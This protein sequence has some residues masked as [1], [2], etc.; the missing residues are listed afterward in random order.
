MIFSPPR[1]KNLKV[2]HQVLQANKV[3]D[4]VVVDDD[5]D[6]DGNDDVG[7]HIDDDVDVFYQVF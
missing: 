5:G 3:I 2:F 1:S 6:D 7:V 4:L